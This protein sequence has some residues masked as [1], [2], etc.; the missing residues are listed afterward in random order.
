MSGED[1]ERLVR[2]LREWA[3][4]EPAI[5]GIALIGSPVRGTARPPSGVSLVVLQDGLPLAGGADWMTR[6]GTVRHVSHEDRGLMQSI[7]V[8]YAD[9]NEVAFGFASPGWAATEPCH[10]DTLAVVGNGLRVVYDPRRWLRQLA[11]AARPDPVERDVVKSACGRYE[12]QIW[13]VPGRSGGRQELA[14]FLDGELYLH[15][16][17]CLPVLRDATTLGDVPSM[18]CVFVSFLDFEARHRDHT[19]DPQ[20]AR[21]IAEDVVRWARQRDERITRQGHLL[22]GVSLSGLAAAYTAL[23]HPE[24]FSSALCQSGSFWWLADHAVSF[25]PTHARLWMSVG[26]EEVETG[27]THPPTGLFQR[28]SQIEG[29]ERAA[30]AFASLGATVH[31]NL[32]SGGHAFPPWRDELA[33]AL[34]WLLGSTGPSH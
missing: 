14:V 27:V 7:R 6:F 11:I 9:G 5:L 8:Q 4:H 33:P 29:V 21:F 17:D 15:D 28:V 23:Q 10:A 18:S 3:L 24:T 32:Y 30:R 12:R 25:P 2:D 16:L 19:C 22:C 20:Y 1:V 13:F 26:T 31:Y 34:R